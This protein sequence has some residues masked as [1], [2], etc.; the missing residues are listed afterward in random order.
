MQSGPLTG[1]AVAVFENGLPHKPGGLVLA[2]S[3]VKHAALHKAE[4]IID[5]VVLVGR[6]QGIALRHPHGLLN[7]IPD[8]PHDIVMLLPVELEPLEGFIGGG[9]PG[10]RSPF[11]HTP[12]R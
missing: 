1:D 12:S 8:G 2:I 3:A 11:P 10:C 4:E 6:R 5:F 7:P 9:Y